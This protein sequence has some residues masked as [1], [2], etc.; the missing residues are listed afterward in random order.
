MLLKF[1]NA[2]AFMNYVTK[3]YIKFDKTKKNHYLSLLE[4]IVYD[5]VSGVHEHIIKLMHYHN[6][7][8]GM[9]VDLRDNFLI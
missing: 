1:Q 3:K 6:Q 9:S 8:N 4:K 2:K 7:L 5:R